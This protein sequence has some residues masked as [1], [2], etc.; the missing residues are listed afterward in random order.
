MPHR[1]DSA[2]TAAGDVTG[3]ALRLCFPCVFRPG[4]FWAT[5]TLDGRRLDASLCNV[6]QYTIAMQRRRSF[7]DFVFCGTER[8]RRSFGFVAFGNGG[9]LIGLILF[10]ALGKADGGLGFGSGRTGVLFSLFGL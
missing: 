6:Q 7:R 8:T 5:L 2:D 3:A 10:A 9:I 4:E 1:H